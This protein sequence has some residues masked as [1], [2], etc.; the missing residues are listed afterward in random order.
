MLFLHKYSAG[1]KE[2]SGMKNLMFCCFMVITGAVFGQQPTLAKQWDK[3]YGGLLQDE[4][5]SCI[6]TADGGYLLGG[7]VYS[8]IGGDKTQDNWD[9]TYNTYDF[10]VVKTDSLGNKQW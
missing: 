7:G 9:T 6:H 1:T 2:C 5:Y 10:W 3:R 8:G 4:L